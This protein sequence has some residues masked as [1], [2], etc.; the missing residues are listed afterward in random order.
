MFF[1]YLGTYESSEIN[2]DVDGRESTNKMTVYKLITSVE[3]AKFT[4]VSR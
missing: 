3:K 4:H 1:M 2:I